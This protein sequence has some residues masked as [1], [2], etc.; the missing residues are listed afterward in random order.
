M[1]SQ[2][3][4]KHCFGKSSNNILTA[5]FAMKINWVNPSIRKSKAIIYCDDGIQVLGNNTLGSSENKAKCIIKCSIIQYS[6]IVSE[7]MVIYKPE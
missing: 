2:S 6:Y 1:S 4:Q 3:N 7:F 5:V